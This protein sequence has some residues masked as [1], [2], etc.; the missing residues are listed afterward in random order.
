MSHSPVDVTHN[1]LVY[2]INGSSILC[3]CSHPLRKF[4]CVKCLLS[5]RYD[6]GQPRLDCDMQPFVGVRHTSGDTGGTVWNERKLCDLLQNSVPVIPA[7]ISQVASM[8]STVRRLQM[9]RQHQIQPYT[10]PV[11]SNKAYA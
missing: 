8:N 2:T 9:A 11:L 6:A 7:S 10:C 1:V 5:C 4:A 3:Q